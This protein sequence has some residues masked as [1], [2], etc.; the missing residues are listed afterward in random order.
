MYLSQGI[1]PRIT[2]P[3][4][5]LWDAWDH[6]ESPWAFYVTW[7]EVYSLGELNM[8][9][10]NK[11]IRHLIEERINYLLKIDQYNIIENPP[12][13]GD[14]ILFTEIYHQLAQA[15]DKSILPTILITMKSTAHGPQH[16]LSKAITIW[17]NHLSVTA[18]KLDLQKE[19]IL[20]TNLLDVIDQQIKN[21]F[22]GDYRITNPQ[23]WS[24]GEDL[25][26]IKWKWDTVKITTNNED[27]YING[28]YFS[29]IKDKTHIISNARKIEGDIDMD[30]IVFQILTNV[31]YYPNM[32][33]QY[34]ISRDTYQ[35]I[36][37]L[38]AIGHANYKEK[39]IKDK[40]KKK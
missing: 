26:Q 14:A 32:Y 19:W 34:N 35:K 2:Y 22:I 10:N 11:S 27:N 18:G 15:K 40:K 39:K 16:L 3:K 36:I 38:I 37:A 12:S 17:R 25:I 33:E 20:K 13:E 9:K 24:N 6:I 29:D 28:I 4:A 23:T 5:E 8:I 31:W 21:I 7:T 30:N 1:D